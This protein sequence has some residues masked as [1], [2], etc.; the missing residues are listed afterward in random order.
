MKRKRLLWQI[1]SSY[2]FITVL[3]ILAALLFASWSVRKFYFAQINSGLEDRARLLQAEVKKLLR[4]K[5]GQVDEFCKGL[6]RRSH[7]RVTVALPSGKVIC[8]SEEDPANM[9][10]HADRP[11]I[12]HALAGKTGVKTRYSHTLEKDMVY[13]AVPVME[14]SKVAG[15]LRTSMP[16]AS[17]GSEL[18][19]VHGRILLAGIVIAAAAAVTSYITARR[20]I[21]ALGEMKAAAK[22]FTR[23]DLSIRLPAPDTEEMAGLAESL[24]EMAAQLDR[25]IR[26][27]TRQRNEREAI[28]ASMTEGVIALDTRQ[29]IISM[30]KAAA[31][32]LGLDPQE[33]VTKSIQEVVRKP[34]LQEISARALHEKVHVEDELVLYKPEELILQSHADVLRDASGNSLGVVIVMNDITALRKLESIRKDFVANVSHEL[35]TPFTSI[36]GFVETLQDGAINEPGDAR[37]FLAI[38][39]KQVDQLNAL[40]DDLLLLSRIEQESEKK[41]I[42]LEQ[43]RIKNALDSAIEVCTPKAAEKNIQIILECENDLTARMNHTLLS[44][45][46][47]NLIDNAVKYSQ[48]QSKV[49]VHAS[50][51]QGE[52]RIKVEDQGA[53]I[54]AEHLPR[55]FERFY[56]VDKARSR[57]M[58]GTGLGLAI[59]KHI[60]QANRGHVSVASTPGSGS[61]F[62]I[63]LPADENN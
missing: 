52:V 34:V 41:E 19:K 39:S 61:V 51:E 36:K 18:R 43:M 30:N 44:H 33:V 1:Y 46:V 55:L 21:I 6:G 42:G 22:K 15:V 56:R 37:K 50:R 57:R 62:T 2:L 14:D 25:N 28:L 4:V 17:V 40:I 20:V 27:I 58:G 49:K 29:K 53:G 5:P 45:A 26:T 35:R 12:R 10:N 11:E 32:M 47:S 31:R 7:T 54:E 48:P 16:L 63:H 38:I 13:V 23:G 60:V 8:D 24:N 59:V 3:S 9:D